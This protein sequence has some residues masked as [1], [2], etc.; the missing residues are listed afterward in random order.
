MHTL[1][2]PKDSSRFRFSSRL[3]K[4]AASYGEISL[5]SLSL[6]EILV[7]EGVDT[8]GIVL[9]CCTESSGFIL[10]LTLSC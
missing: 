6:S 8:S 3:C 4:A 2:S 10:A 5:Y 9:L 1:I 7:T